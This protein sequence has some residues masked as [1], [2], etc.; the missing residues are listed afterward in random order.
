MPSLA[1]KGKGHHVAAALVVVKE[2]IGLHASP[3]GGVAGGTALR[4]PGP[5]EALHLAIGEASGAALGPG[6]HGGEAAAVEDDDLDA[7]IAGV[8]GVDVNVDI[9]GDGPSEPATLHVV[10]GEHVQPLAE[11]T[12]TTTAA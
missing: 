8:E 2:A 3:E 11:A 12:T 1:A 4:E 9:D 7:H 10:G 5:V 6:P